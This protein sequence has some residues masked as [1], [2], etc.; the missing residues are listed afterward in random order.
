MLE[1]KNEKE[2]G[3]PD[4]EVIAEARSKCATVAAERVKAYEKRCGQEGA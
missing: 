4:K 2:K 1:G 3:Y